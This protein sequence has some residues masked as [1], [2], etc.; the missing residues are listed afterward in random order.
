MIFDHLQHSE[1]YES[2]HPLFKQAF[3]YLKQHDLSQ[4]P[5]GKIELDGSRLYISIQEPQGKTPQ[6]AKLETHNR[7]IDIQVLL[8][9]AESI[10]WRD[11]D[12]C[13][14]PKDAYNPEKDITFFDDAPTCDVELTPG[15]FCI[16]F[17]GDAHAPCIGNGPIKKVVVKVLI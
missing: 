6:A 17:P 4:A 8:Q 13:H 5:A 2:L 14:L 1:A 12:D 3:D 7:Y 15:D 16:L 9:G 10:G 11:A